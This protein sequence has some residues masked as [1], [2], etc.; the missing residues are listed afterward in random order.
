MGRGWLFGLAAALFWISCPLLIWLSASAYVDV[1]VAVYALLGLYALRVYFQEQDERW[2]LLSVAM[3]SMSAASKLPGAFFVGM[4]FLLVAIRGRRLRPLLLGAAVALATSGGFFLWITWHTGNPLWPIASQYSK[5]IYGAPFVVAPMQA[6]YSFTAAE[7]TVWGFVQLPVELIRNPAFWEGHLP[8]VPFL[9]AWPLALLVPNREA[10]WWSLWALGFTLFWFLGP[11]RLRYLYP[12]LPA[13][14][15]AFCAAL[16]WCLRPRR[17]RSVVLVV[18]TAAALYWPIRYV[19]EWRRIFGP[20]PRTASAQESFL[21]R[22]LSG[23][24]GVAALNERAGSGDVVY[25][26]AASW[27]TY[28]MRPRVVDYVGELQRRVWPKYRWPEDRPFIEY[29][30]GLGVRWIFIHHTPRPY[31]VELPPGVPPED[32]WP[33]FRVVYKDETT[34]VFE[35]K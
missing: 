9:A 11:H 32:Y 13:A 30:D 20:I 4:A 18:L 34:W 17:V 25:T 28:Q 15:L 31:Y 12:A 8:W 2:W 7:R 33:M 21:G 27:L 5:G 22:V 26:I 24:H 35:R 16:D 10:R 1:Q 29:L 6:T 14:I 19:R 23:Y 3:L